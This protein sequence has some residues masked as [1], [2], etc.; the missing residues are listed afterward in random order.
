MDYDYYIATPSLFKVSNL[1]TLFPS[2]KEGI[3]IEPI[4]L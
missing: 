4:V 3:L 1:L 2:R